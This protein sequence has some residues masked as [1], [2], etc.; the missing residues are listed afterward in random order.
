MKEDASDPLAIA[1]LSEIDTLE[2]LARGRLQ[3]ALPKGME[4]SQFAVLNHFARLGGE[5]TPAQL[6]R[7]FHVTRG[8]MTNTLKKLETSGWIHIRPDW[9]DGRK[10]WVSISPAGRSARNFAVAAIAPVFEDVM[11]GMGRDRVRAALP[12]LRDLRTY[13]SKE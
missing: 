8:T 6:A 7:S 12:F 2:Q 4:L 1:L 9:E 3:R 5:K 11:V 10:K 13:L